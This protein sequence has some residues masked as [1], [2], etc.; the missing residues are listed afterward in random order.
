M[1]KEVLSATP[2]TRSGAIE[3]TTIDD[4]RRII[5]HQ[6]RWYGLDQLVVKD[7][8]RESLNLIAVT[9]ADLD[10]NETYCR[11]FPTT[12]ADDVMPAMPRDRMAA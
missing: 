2:A 5:D 1:I 3:V 10:R 6:L 12:L 11:Y 8:R 9:L 4:V 7:I